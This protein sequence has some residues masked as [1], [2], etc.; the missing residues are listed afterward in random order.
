MT[1][2]KTIEDCLLHADDLR[3]KYRACLLRLG[4]SPDYHIYNLTFEFLNGS[5][6]RKEVAFLL[7]IRRFYDALPEKD[8]PIFVREVLER[9][10]HYPF[11][12]YDADYKKGEFERRKNDLLYRV[13]GAL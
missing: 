3:A 11:W 1:T 4:K 2:I 6:R 12:F 8:K 13:V 5:K 9:N 7:K 10:R